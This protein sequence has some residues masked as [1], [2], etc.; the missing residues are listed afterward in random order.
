MTWTLKVSRQRIIVTDPSNTTTIHSYVHEK[1]FGDSYFTRSSFNLSELTL[2]FLY[3]VK[4]QLL[5]EPPLSP[6]LTFPPTHTQDIRIYDC[7]LDVHTHTLGLRRSGLWSYVRSV[8][9]SPTLP[10]YNFLFSIIHLR[11]L[12]YYLHISTVRSSST[13]VSLS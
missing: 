9:Y 3:Y 4:K 6:F 7:G 2:T 12:S 1:A 10:E 5:L 13:T 8:L 11:S